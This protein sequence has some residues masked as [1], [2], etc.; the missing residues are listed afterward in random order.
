[1]KRKIIAM[2]LAICCMAP[3]LAGCSQL[4]SLLSLFP[5]S[6]GQNAA[7]GEAVT[8]RVAAENAPLFEGVAVVGEALTLLSEGTEFIPDGIAIFGDTIWV[9]GAAPGYTGWI[10]LK[11]LHFDY[12]DRAGM[13]PVYTPEGGVQVYLYPD[14]VMSSFTNGY[15]WLEISNIC[16]YNGN[17]WGYVKDVGFICLN[18]ITLPPNFTL[19]EQKNADVQLDYIELLGT[20]YCEIDSYI[21]GALGTEETWKF[22]ED[23]TFFL[24]TNI[25][26]DSPEK[27]NERELNGGFWWREGEILS[28]SFRELD[29]NDLPTEQRL[30]QVREYLIIQGQE[31]PVL[32][33]M[34]RIALSP[35]KTYGEGGSAVV[36][37]PTEEKP[38]SGRKL[39]YD[40]L[41]GTWQAHNGDLSSAAI[42][43]DLAC[44]KKGKLLWQ[45]SFGSI[46]NGEFIPTN[47]SNTMLESA[48]ISGSEIIFRIEKVV[49]GGSEY[50]AYVGMDDYFKI[51]SVSDNSFVLAD[52]D[53]TE[54]KF[55]RT[56]DTN[57]LMDLLS[58]TLNGSSS[59]KPKP[60]ESKPE[61]SKPAKAKHALP[62]VAF[63]TWVSENASG[64][65]EE[66]IRETWKFSEREDQV[67][68]GYY[69]IHAEYSAEIRNGDGEFV[70]WLYN[71]SF[72]F[73]GYED[74]LYY[75]A[76]GPDPLE[77]FTIEAANNSILIKAFQFTG[78]MTE[79]YFYRE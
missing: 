36:N 15:D 48:T 4:G 49:Y 58:E 26:I 35:F 64:D 57:G 5:D 72:E 16:L 37:K 38:A 11:Y 41:Y 39:T 25:Y 55:R 28:L 45:V 1:M 78:G 23:G 60:E 77:P 30:D 6:P 50:D 56:A 61:S 40:Y 43:F 22:N 31:G 68:N 34:D 29:D 73:L 10:E 70:Q 79:R 18:D 74:G 24:T 63:G 66:V 76:I 71:G 47:F 20:W 3:L 65:G 14:A 13:L 7:A 12:T 52:I 62:S 59:S 33:G 51:V 67:V 46:H 32:C 75:F 42:A 27:P 19:P 69:Y 9:S 54:W 21:D 2:L 44:N 8:A 17:Y 53:G